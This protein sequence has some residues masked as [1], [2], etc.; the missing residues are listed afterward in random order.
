MNVYDALAQAGITIP[1]PQRVVTMAD[2]TK[3]DKSVDSKPATEK[4]GKAPK[5]GEHEQESGAASETN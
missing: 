3:E 1:F 4:K 2:P 5:S